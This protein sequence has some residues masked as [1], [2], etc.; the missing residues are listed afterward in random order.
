MKRITGIILAGGK[1]TRMGK[2]KGLLQLNGQTFI[3]HIYETLKPICK[4]VIIISNQKEHK[5]FQIPL[6]ED[7]HKNKGPL[8]GIYTGL[9][10]SGTNR[11][12]IVGCDMPFLSIALLKYISKHIDS[13]H[14]TI[15]PVF[16][17][18]TQPLCAIYSKK[19]LKQLENMINNDELKMKEAIGNL[20]TKY[21]SIDEN[22]SFYR[23]DLFRNMNTPHDLESIKNFNFHEN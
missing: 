14:D 23:P 3:E 22:T 17:G 19:N 10:H 12:F 5:Q 11:N 1:S 21:I 2:D 18:A 9:Y 4:K 15:V 13:F 7:I 16:D 8:G 6:F 20:N